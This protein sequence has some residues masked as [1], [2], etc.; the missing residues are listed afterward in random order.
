MNKIKTKL[1]T[2]HTLQMLKFTIV[3]AVN[4]TD[5]VFLHSVGWIPV[6]HLLHS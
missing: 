5:H 1:Q 6:K 3:L 4:I 2:S